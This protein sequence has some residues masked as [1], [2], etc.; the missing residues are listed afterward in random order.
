MK[1]AILIHS[2]DI[3]ED[4]SIL[5]KYSRVKE[6]EPYKEVRGHGY[7]GQWHLLI[8][9]KNNWEKICKKHKIN[10]HHT[11]NPNK[12][13]PFF[14]KITKCS[15]FCYSE[16]KT[17]IGKTMQVMID[18]VNDQYYKIYPPLPIQKLC[19]S[20]GNYSRKGYIYGISVEDCIRVNSK[21]E[22]LIADGWI[23]FKKSL[24]KK[25]PQHLTLK[26][27]HKLN[28]LVNH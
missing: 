2:R 11:F 24:S 23:K 8:A 15:H 17:L 22:K 1:Q 6:Y 28:E 10:Y 5:Q 16:N 19:N 3:E 25:Y 7:E 13:K 4:K 18:P 14:V 9:E 12:L 27:L 21:N 20:D 26:S